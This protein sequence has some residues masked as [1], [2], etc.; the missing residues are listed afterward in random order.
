MLGC[1]Y[2][3]QPPPS[4]RIS[5]LQ[6]WKGVQQVASCTAQHPRLALLVVLPGLFLAASPLKA[7]VNKQRVTL[8]SGRYSHQNPS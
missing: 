5:R 8:K 3:L 7:Q 6:D 4:S 2:V 1:L